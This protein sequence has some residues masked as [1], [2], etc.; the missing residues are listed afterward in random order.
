MMD[1][2]SLSLF[3]PRFV[4]A[5]GLLIASPLCAEVNVALNK[6]SDG[7]TAFNYPTANGNDGSVANFT[8][9]DNTNGAPSNPYWRVNLQGV[10]DLTRI[11]IVDRTS[12]CDPNRLNGSEIRF[13]DDAQ[14]QIGG[15]LTI[16][17]LPANNVAATATVTFN[18]AG[19]GWEGVSYVRIDGYTQYFQFAEFR[20]FAAD[21]PP[22]ENSN[23]A[24]G[25]PVIASGATWNGFPP[26]LIADGNPSSFSHPLTNVGTQGFYYQIDLQSGS[27]LDRILVRNRNDG[28][29]PERLSNYKVSLLADS[30]GNPGAV[31]WSASVRTNGTNS[32]SGGIDTLRG[33][34]GAGTFSGRFVR[35]EN[36]STGG[37][38]PQIAEV[39]V[40][41]APL[42]VI[43]FFNTSAGNI[44][45]TGAPG[46]PTSATLSW[47]V[48]NYDS[49]AITPGIG[50]VS[51][52]GGNRNVTPATT[53]TYT[54]TATNA[55]GT[56][57]ATVTVGVDEP[58]LAPVLSEFLS[59]NGQ[60]IED[61][62]GSHQDWIE[63]YNPN[64]F[65]LNV[66]GFYLTDL[67][68]NLTKW[69]LPSAS[70]PANGY[71]IVFASGKNRVDPGGPLHTNFSLS[72]T[73]EY[74]ALI[75][76]DGTTMLGQFPAD[77][78]VT[79]IFPAQGTDIS[80]GVPAGGGEGFLNPPTPGA[81]N[82]TGYAGFVADTKFSVKRGVY[83]S[84]QSVAIT[85]LTP[86]ASIRYTTNGSKPTETVGTLYTGPIN[87][88]A[89]T[90]LRAI[91]FKS[92]FTPSNV[93]THTYVFPADVATSGVMRTAITQDATYGPQVTP[94][95]SDLP[96]MSLV[97][98]STIN[99]NTEVGAS[100][101]FIL[102]DGTPGFQEECGVKNFGGAFTNFPKKSFRLY[103]RGEYGAPKLTYPLFENF[104]RGGIESVQEF[105]QLNL[106]SGSHD[107]KQ[108]GFY[109]SNRFTDDTMLDAGEV[110]P[111]GR[112]VHLY[113]NGTYWGLY[114]LRE[115]WHAAMLARYL[116]G[117]K[118][119][120]ESINGNYNV[121][122][123]AVPG[124]PYDGDGSV[125]ERVKTLGGNY[126]AVRPYLDVR[127]YVDYMLMFM[128]G[129]SEDEYRASGPM[130]VGSGLK[131][132]LNDADG[133]TRAVGNRTARGA[134]GRLNGDGPGSIFSLLVTEGHPDFK[135]LLADRIHFL[136]FND[137]PMTPA[138][139]LA[140]IQE[141][142]TE[143]QRPMIPEIA[144]WGGTGGLDSYPSPANWESTK[145]AYVS[146]VLPT[147][148]AAVIG[149]YRGA[150]LY[151]ATSAPVL[152]QHGGD[153]AKGFRATLSAPSG[154]IYYTVD[155][156]DPRLPGG[157]ISPGASEYDDGTVSQ[158]MV[159]HGAVWKFLDTGADLGASDI[160]VG[161]P[162]YS[163]AQWKHP[164]F[165]DSGWAS[166]PAVFGYGEADVVTPVSYGPSST[167]KY[168]TTYFRHSF[169]LANVGEVLS[170][171][172]DI[173]RDDGAIIYLNGQEIARTSMNAGPTGSTTLAITAPDDGVDFNPF[174]VPPGVLV[175]GRN[176]LAIELHQSTATSS[177]LR[178]DFGLSVLRSNSGTGGNL[179][180]DRNT[181]IRARAK[182]GAEWSAVNEALFTVDGAP[183]VSPGEVV[184][185]E[186]HYHPSEAAS[187]EFIEVTNVSDHAV[188]LR[189]ARF[190][191]GV[192][193]T[194]ADNFDTVLA[195][196]RR[197]LLV[198]SLYSFQ[199]TYGI[200]LPVAGIYAGNLDNDGELLAL[201]SSSGTPLFRFTYNDSAIWPQAPDGQ[202]DSLVFRGG[203]P[204][205]P[206]N[207]RSSG[208]PPT[209][210]ASKGT[211]FA[212]DPLAD[213]NRNGVA[214]L[215]DYAMG[216]GAT[217]PA[218]A[219][220]AEGH[221]LVTYE[222][223][224]AAD[225][226]ILDFEAAPDLFDWSEEVTS[227]YVLISREGSGGTERLVFRKNTPI[228]P[229]E[230]VF[231]RLRATLR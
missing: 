187:G 111:H 60:S 54:L 191:D 4:S 31:N 112:Y 141:Q 217:G 3:R 49:L 12:C 40:Y 89:T 138:R 57:S 88:G 203:D 199:Q 136:F 85:T 149:Y 227:T 134:P 168:I 208:G 1:F 50:T 83:S 25:K 109:L 52:P 66:E 92:G 38:S 160:V 156:S 53:T 9:A 74:L 78:P 176:V 146:G 11:E 193:Y 196:G 44:T 99:G 198:G 96:S 224:L 32:G 165:G 189:G 228:S 190:T 230:D 207:W 221:L 158:T 143:V 37:Y 59:D 148:T 192:E 87:V 35:V 76:R 2:L 204:V 125:W 231:I 195:S 162:A 119:D 122:G 124:D 26:T 201:E 56:K 14:Q 28:C 209:P 166:G 17:G 101:E 84:P 154:T 77:F 20:A 63:I 62:D 152:N 127:H 183:A 97:T 48:S 69:R 68:T 91:A 18:N 72:R 64:G 6:P 100:L 182:N 130:G 135:V 8:H 15:V 161:H 19:A 132:F 43:A 118:E 81:A 215:L 157:A 188:N 150:G 222:R 167:N 41:G 220:D 194:F 13:F 144:R 7:D 71:L 137:G 159:P 202:G 36:L 123:W 61:E 197:L 210:L 200:D 121:G 164:D 39:E 131:W 213:A 179:T 223:A 98:P 65:S 205:D 86:G 145:N 67:A 10:F 163:S 90:V 93:D 155:G 229:G 94:A 218:L 181:W 47:S 27:F 75:A 211:T 142:V 16:S 70:I 212:G 42:P 114:H 226:V 128:F 73:G 110:N 140:R 107:M 219:F 126:T 178:F 133:Y 206:L 30:G 173:R 172:L 82:G 106:R 186:L 45:A 103:F 185:S 184:V 113:L 225:D 33:V 115:R 108:R 79:G 117:N 29:C 214:D 216:E 139:N 34:D 147:Q 180:L 5:L 95:L 104:E 23:L 51:G 169:T 102:P 46:L 22:G 24:L 177:D 55:T 129:N 175:E 171:S 170:A 21:P 58:E 80:Y 116:G 120:Y 174:A 151:P 105:D 153:V